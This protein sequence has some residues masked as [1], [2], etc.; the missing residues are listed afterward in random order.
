MPPL[1]NSLR[2][3]I[4]DKNELYPFSSYS[5]RKVLVNL[6]TENLRK[7]KN[8][9]RWLSSRQRHAWAR[10]ESRLLHRSLN[11]ALS[12]LSYIRKIQACVCENIFICIACVY[13]RVCDFNDVRVQ[14]DFS[15]VV[16]TCET[17][18]GIC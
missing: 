6:M 5:L 9:L 16:T 15:D 4:A 14:R 2:V 13:V 17:K 7:M 10:F 3:A 18:I 11:L 1:S 12:A 8:S